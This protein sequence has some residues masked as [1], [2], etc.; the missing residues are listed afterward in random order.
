MSARRFAVSNIALTA[1]DHIEELSRV[2][3]LGFQGLEVAPSRVWRDTWRGLTNQQVAA[4]RR[5]VETAGLSVIGLHSLLFNQPDLGLFEESATRARTLDF[6]VHLSEVCRDLGG[7]SL[8]Y[9]GGRRRNGTAA[10]D[11]KTIALDFIGNYVARTSGHGTCLCFEP[12]APKDTDFVN[13][14]YDALELVR[15]I[16][17]S[18]F[19]VQLDAKALVDNNEVIGTVFDDCAGE[20]VHFHANEPGFNV[21]GSSENVNHAFFGAQLNRIGYNGFVSIEQRMIDE[22]DALGPIAKSYDVLCSAYAN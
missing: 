2:A 5:H 6:L 15:A 1:Y 19:R 14:A 17:H 8:I 21:L 9:G 22:N 18:A 20:L 16:D 10:A 13:S 3:D 4:Y 7:R 12:L 11:A